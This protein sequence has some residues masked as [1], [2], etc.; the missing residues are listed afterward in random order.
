MLL[1]DDHV[2]LCFFLIRIVV[3]FQAVADIVI[4]RHFQSEINPVCLSVRLDT[5]KYFS[6]LYLSTI[7]SLWYLFDKN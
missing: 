6:V 3:Y 1:D 2:F 4:S 7:H 5:N